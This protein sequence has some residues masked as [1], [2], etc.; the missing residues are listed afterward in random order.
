MAAVALAILAFVVMEPVAYL[1]H[2][3]VMHGP[4]ARV[5]L[6]HHRSERNGW[7][8]NDLF[9]IVF[10]SIVMVAM[11]LGYQ[12]DRFWALVPIGV[13]ITLYGVA[14]AFVHDVYVHRRLPLVRRRV[15]VLEHLA[16]AHRAHHRDSGEPYGMLLPLTRSG[17]RAAVGEPLQRVPP[18]PGAR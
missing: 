6:S 10:A 3:F 16:E 8:A 12:V 17:R 5:H 9:P 4:A 13:G 1:V 14:Y 7:Q 15:A 2:R 11:T 18:I